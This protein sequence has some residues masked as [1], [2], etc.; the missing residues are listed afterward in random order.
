[1]LGR[2]RLENHYLF[3]VSLELYSKNQ[4]YRV[5]SFLKCDSI[6]AHSHM[7]TFT[8]YKIKIKSFWGILHNKSSA[9]KVWLDAGSY[10]NCPSLLKI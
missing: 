3:K 9:H 1:M 2:L 5:R 4:G 10:L 7:Y 8:H 6:H